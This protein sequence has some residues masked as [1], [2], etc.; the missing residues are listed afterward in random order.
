MRVEVVARPLGGPPVEPPDA[1]TIAREQ[2]KAVGDRRDHLD[3]RQ[4]ADRRV[5]VGEQGNE[6][7]RHRSRSV[8]RVGDERQGAAPERL[9]D[10]VGGDVPDPV[11]EAVVGRRRPVVQLVGVEDVQLTRE[12]DVPPTPVAECLHAGDGDADRVGVVSVRHERTTR[13]VQL[14]P[15]EPGQA[16]PKPDRVGPAPAR[17]FKTIAGDAS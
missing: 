17:S 9:G 1:G 2:A 3:P 16:R 11:A 5:D 4:L 14:G 10:E 7:R 6:R 8:D 13:E 12:T 15:L